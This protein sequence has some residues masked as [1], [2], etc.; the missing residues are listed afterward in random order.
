MAR[1]TIGGVKPSASDVQLDGEGEPPKEKKPRR[2]LKI[3]LLL[4]VPWIVLGGIVVFM[5]AKS[6]EAEFAM[7][8]EEAAKVAGVT[9]VPE[10][11]EPMSILLVGTD[12]R[13]EGEQARADSIIFLYTNPDHDRSY[14]ISVQRDTRVNIP[15]RGMDK[16]NHSYAFGEAPL[17]IETVSE[18]FSLDVN[19]FMKVDFESLEQVVDALGGVQFE[20][21][22]SCMDW[23]LD[24]NVRKGDLL[25]PG[26]EAL[27]IVRCRKAYA[28]GDFSRMANQQAMIAAIAD[29]MASKPTSLP[30]IAGIIAEHGSTNMKLSAM[31]GTG[32]AMLGTRD[33]LEKGKLPTKGTKIS[34]VYYGVY[35]QD[36][37]DGIGDAMRNGLPLP[38]YATSGE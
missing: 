37:L 29:E 4:T 32:R 13:T 27:A 34:G 21:D 31:I 33:N 15:G 2:W 3:T 11:G 1:H 8:P 19:Y 35:D 18:L 23:E 16:I 5:W 9:E 17:L 25:R 7:D 38:E 12:E 26:R 20:T 28:D 22:R 30:G 10:S 6:F 36:E 24:T 14:M